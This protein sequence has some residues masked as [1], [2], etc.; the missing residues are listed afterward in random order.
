MV[1]LL[2]RITSCIMA[3]LVLALACGAASADQTWELPK[4]DAPGEEPLVRA[5]PPTGLTAEAVR[6]EYGEN[7][8]QNYAMAADLYCRAARKGD[9]DAAYR[10]GWMYANGRGMLKDD[11]LATGLFRY[12][13]ERS[14]D[15]AKRMLEHVNTTEAVL[16]A[17]MIPPSVIAEE[18]HA[19]PLAWT[20]TPE[21]MKIVEIVRE[22]APAYGVEP[23]LALAI[24]QAESGFQVSAKSNKNAQGLMQ[25]IPETAERFGVRKI[26]DPRE[27]IRGGLA[28]LRW[29]LSYFEGDVTLVTAAY[30]AGEGAVVRYRGVPPYAET[31]Q[32]VA[33][34]TGVYGK[35][36]HKFNPGVVEP[37]AM[38]LVRRLQTVSAVE[39]RAR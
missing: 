28:Y 9:A 4:A 30:N 2:P 3:A 37:A 13:A 35:V 22:F 6:L 11:R 18:S 7:I 33:R 31:R 21:R 5:P 39:A 1:A 36:R 24:I 20:A 23:R 12:A 15:Y 38:V 10:L 17:C 16:P 14:H 26:M 27:N 19:L 32:Y 34:V 8:A 29:L 25:L